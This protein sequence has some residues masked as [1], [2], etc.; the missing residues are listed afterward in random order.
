MPGMLVSKERAIPKSCR[1]DRGFVVKPDPF[2]REVYQPVFRVFGWYNSG[3]V[4]KNF[5]HA[6]G[7]PEIKPAIGGI[8][9]KVMA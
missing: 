9:I 5:L 6:N 8:L 3:Q 2:D 7:R 4:A 1:K